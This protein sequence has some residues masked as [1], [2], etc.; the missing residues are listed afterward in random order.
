MSIIRRF[1][2][3]K[4]CSCSFIRFFYLWA[5]GNGD[6]FIFTITTF[7]IFEFEL[8]PLTC[9][10]EHVVLEKLSTFI[11]Y[12]PHGTCQHL[13]AH[14]GFTCMM[15]LLVLQNFR[16]GLQIYFSVVLLCLHVYLLHHAFVIILVI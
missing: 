2:S 8:F 11:G 1:F 7:N 16:R 10:F 4:A 5:G 3:F 12:S 13:N 6:Y 14:G 15:A 9:I